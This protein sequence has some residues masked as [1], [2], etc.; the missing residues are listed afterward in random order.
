ML[1]R[2]IVKN[3]ALIEAAEIEF[4][5]GLNVLSG[6]TGAGK[7]VI[8]DSINFALGAKA[9]KSMIRYGENECSVRAV[10]LAESD[11]P[12][13][14]TLRDM[15]IDADEEIIVSRRYRQDGR[16]DIKVNGCN[17]NASMLRKI[18]SHLVDVHGQSEHF[19]LLSESNQLK[20][21]DKEA[22]EPLLKKKGVLSDLLAKRKR[23]SE[24]LLSL[25]GDETERG[26][27]LDILRYQIDEIDRAQLRDGEEEELL[28]KKVFFANAEKIIHAISEAAQFM[29]SDGAATDLLRSARRSMSEIS[30]LSEEY[31][32][33][34]NRLESTALEAEDLSE[35]LSALAE[36]LSYDEREAEETESRLDHIRALKKKYGDS[37]AKIFSYRDSIEEE[38]DLL[39]HCDEEYAKLTEEKAKNLSEIFRCC[40]GITEERKKIAARFCRSVEE[41]LRTLNIKNAQFCAEFSPYTEED[42][43]RAGPDGLDRVS[44]MF[45]ANAGEPLKPLN[46]VISGGEMS[47]LMLAIKTKTSSSNEIATYIFDE[48]D[49]GI[50]GATAKTVAEK[51]AEISLKKQ[52]IAV[53]HLAQIAAMADSNFLIFKEERADGKT[54]T[55]IR[56]LFGPERFSELVRLLGGTEKSTAARTLAEELVEFSEDYKRKCRQSAE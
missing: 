33:L 52:I 3:V 19:Y 14:E 48:I 2:L 39:S 43:E 16:G 54:I 24:K 30:S 42:A 35:T 8:L 34:E 51:F 20:L 53:S 12:V 44:F 11:N 31:A 4:G 9:D 46:K 32:Q 17:V 1:N 29:G 38:Y 56:P 55:D 13:F 49:A 26:R 41:E 50:S 6:E 37:V 21:L 28:A 25:G 10:F 27:R 15:D 47:R 22:G 18:T 7:S 5:P 45:S 23:I 36:D 40:V